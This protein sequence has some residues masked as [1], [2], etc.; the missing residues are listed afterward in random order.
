MLLRL[1]GDSKSSLV[2]MLVGSCLLF[3]LLVLKL[4][5]ETWPIVYIRISSPFTE[6]WFYYFTGVGWY[7]GPVVIAI[8]FFLYALGQARRTQEQD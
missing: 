6:K 1:P 7:V 4:G 2:L 5:D 3:L 8:G